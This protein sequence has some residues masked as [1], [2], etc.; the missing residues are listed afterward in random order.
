MVLR[1]Q[2][3]WKEF[4]F[5][6]SKK[7]NKKIL[8]FIFN[9]CNVYNIARRNKYTIYS[10]FTVTLVKVK[11]FIFAIRQLLEPFISTAFYSRFVLSFYY[12]VIFLS[13]IN[14]DLY[15]IGFFFYSFNKKT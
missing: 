15:K 11:W 1:S 9:I 14:V 5:I 7:E 12:G 4:Y 10:W 8:N 13:S 2:F 3:Y 6:Y